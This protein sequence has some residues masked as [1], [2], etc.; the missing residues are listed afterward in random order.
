MWSSECDVAFDTLKDNLTSAP[1]LRYP[2]WNKKFHVHVDAPGKSLGAIITQ[3][4]EG[5]MDHH[6]Y[7]TSRE[8][9]NAEKNYTTR[10]WESL[11]MVYSLQ[12]F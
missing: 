12:N 1:I 10:E 9:S 3:S 11:S 7:F 4:G 2:D 8:N 6:V 5:N